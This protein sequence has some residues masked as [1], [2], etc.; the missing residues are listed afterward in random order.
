MELLGRIPVQAMILHTECYFLRFT[1]RIP[2]STMAT[3]VVPRAQGPKLK[4]LFA[5][6]CYLNKIGQ[7]QTATVYVREILDSEARK[8]KGSLLHLLQ[9]LQLNLGH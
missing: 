6:G 5:V 1:N 3:V 2:T 4:P 8:T 7:L 9:F